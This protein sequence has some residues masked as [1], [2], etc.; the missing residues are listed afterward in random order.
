MS[1]EIKVMNV[2]ESK[3]K[4]EFI[5]KIN[6]IIAKLICK[7]GSTEEYKIILKNK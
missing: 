1:Q 2:C 3:T 7:L 4:D 6:K 5:Y